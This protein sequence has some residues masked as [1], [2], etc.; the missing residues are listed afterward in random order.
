MATPPRTLLLLLV[1]GASTMGYEVQNLGPSCRHTSNAISSILG[2]D[3][4]PVNPALLPLISSLQNSILDSLSPSTLAS[5]WT[6]W[7]SLHNRYQVTFLSSD[8]VSTTYF[9]TSAHSEM[10]IKSQIKTY[11]G[12]MNV[13]CKLL[14]GNT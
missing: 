1:L 4:Q 5:Y 3:V 7:N 14:T 10:A 9:I 6:A 12:G 13:F 11:C 8:L 2:T